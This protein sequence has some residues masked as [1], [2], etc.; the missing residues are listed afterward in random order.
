MQPI[1]ANCTGS[2]K[3]IHA[4]KYT[5]PQ[6]EPNVHFLVNNLLPEQRTKK[7]RGVG[8]IRQLTE[9]RYDSCLRILTAVKKETGLL[10]Q[11]TD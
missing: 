7:T 4:V 10:Y 8:F 6:T 11:L 9:R 2:K 1:N 3:S 5:Q